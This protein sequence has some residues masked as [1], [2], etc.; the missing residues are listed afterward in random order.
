MMMA[1]VAVPAVGVLAACSTGAQTETASVAP[2]VELEYEGAESSLPEGYA[3]PEVVDGF[4]FTVGWLMPGLVNAFLQTNTNGAVEETERLGGE[5]IVLD[6]GFD[7]DT[8]FAQCSQLVAQGVDVIAV[9]PLSA[10][11]L[12]PCFDDATAAG[13]PIVSQEA[14][15]QA[16]DP[17][18][19]NVLTTVIQGIDHP[20]FVAAEH[21]ASMAPGA[22]YALI[23]TVIP[24]DILQ[25]GMKRMQHWAD[26]FGLQFT[27]RVDAQGDSPEDVADA[28]NTIL[29]RNPDVGVILTYSDP[30][31]Q[32]IAATAAAAGRT[33]ILV[34]GHSG[35]Q[36]AIDMV[37]Q[38]VLTGTV[39]LDAE[40]IGIQVIRAAY[41]VLTDQNLPLPA[42][43]KAPF[44]LVTADNAASV[45][46]LSG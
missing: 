4:D 2:T 13:I 17:L 34:Y 8:Q 44:L 12:Q 5:I 10:D 46:G 19:S 18:P 36:A 24:A 16:G 23:G 45:D 3:E 32:A 39:F 14:P 1:L 22:E 31:A 25:R 26:E 37:E 41:N 21:A 35:E 11:A 6:A 38:G 33:D 29:T 9:N 15:S 7:L 27:E 42:Q 20:R 28:M 30:A 43:V 40:Q